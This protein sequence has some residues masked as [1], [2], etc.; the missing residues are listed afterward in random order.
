PSPSV[1]AFPFPVLG[2]GAARRWVKPPRVPPPV[3]V[4]PLLRGPCSAAPPRQ[5]EKP[6]VPAAA[7]ACCAACRERASRDP[8]GMDIRIRPC[9]DYRDLD[10]ACRTYF[11]SHP[12][13]TIGACAK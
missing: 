6:P 4:F 12:E 3:V 2:P 7:A 10:D 11:A 13:I 8:R 1:A 9:A 5:A